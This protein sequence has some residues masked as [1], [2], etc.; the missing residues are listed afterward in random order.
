MRVDGL[1]DCVDGLI[2][3]GWIRLI[4][5][6]TTMV[7]AVTAGVLPFEDYCFGAAK[8]VPMMGSGAENVPPVASAVRVIYFTFRC[9]I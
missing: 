1:I 9:C 7:A 3:S 4:G 2:D 8:D 6:L 5:L